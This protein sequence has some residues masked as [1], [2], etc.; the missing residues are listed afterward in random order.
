MFPKLLAFL[1]VLQ[2]FAGPGASKRTGGAAYGMP[3]NLF[4]VAVAA[5]REVVVPMSSPLEIEAVGCSF[6]ATQEAIA[7]IEAMKWMLRML[8]D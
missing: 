2:S 5:Y 1:G 4:T 8:D 3:K 6:P 7:A